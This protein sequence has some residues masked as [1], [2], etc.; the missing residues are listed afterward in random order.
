MAKVG[1]SVEDWK[2]LLEPKPPPRYNRLTES[3]H[4]LSTPATTPIDTL[5][6][7]TLEMLLY[8]HFKDR[9]LHRRRALDHTQRIQALSQ[10]KQ[11]P[12]PPSPTPK[13]SWADLPDEV[14]PGAY[15]IQTPLGAKSL[16]STSTTSPFAYFPKS[17]RAQGK[18]AETS[19][20]PG[21]YNPNL[22]AVAPRTR[23]A[24]FPS[25]PKCRTLTPI[26]GQKSSLGLKSLSPTP[27]VKQCTFPRAKRY[28]DIRTWRDR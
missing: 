17:G 25:S 8:P 10:P 18:K 7:D 6:R 26:A 3:R 19:P 5:K 14:G 24:F 15:D 27:S 16:L 12:K 13:W 1:I 2:S 21:Q 20:A 22:E 23:V 9:L 4:R 28:I 11:K